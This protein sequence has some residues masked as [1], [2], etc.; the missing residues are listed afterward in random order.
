LIFA[1][2]F[3]VITTSS[4]GGTSG[5]PAPSVPQGQVRTHQSDGSPTPATTKPL[6]SQPDSSPQPE[7]KLLAALEL[8]CGVDR[9]SLANL[10]DSAVFYEQLHNTRDTRFHILSVLSQSQGAGCLR[11]LKLYAQARVGCGPH[12]GVMPWM[13]G[14]NFDMTVARAAAHP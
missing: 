10:A 3:I 13:V 7:E 9:R 11:R 4:C 6:Q 14:C 5:H 2:G 8:R 1:L 12:K